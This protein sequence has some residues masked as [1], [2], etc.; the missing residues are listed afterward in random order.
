[1][2]AKQSLFI[3]V[4]AAGTA[5]HVGELIDGAVAEG[6]EVYTVGSENLAMIMLPADLLARPGVHWVS[7]YG[8]PPL[9]RFPFGTMLVAPCTFNTF[10][11]LAHGIGD[12]LLTAMVADAIGAGLPVFVAP[13]MNHGLWNHPQT[14]ESHQRLTSWGVQII[15]PQISPTRVVMAPIPDVLARIRR[16]FA[17]S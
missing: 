17:E 15:E 13:S 8:A 9:D 5:R 7:N 6:W 2:T 14:R 12:T 1:M 10:N 3:Y 11:K 4:S 16:H